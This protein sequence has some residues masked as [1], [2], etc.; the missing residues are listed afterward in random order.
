MKNTL[1]KIV[2]L[3]LLGTI[4]V[5]SCSMHTSKAD[6]KENI[7]GFYELETYTSKKESPEEDPYDRKAEEG[8]SAYFTIDMDGYGYYG[9]KDNNTPARV[10]AIF[11]TFAHDDEKPELYSSVEIKGT[12][13][14][15][16]AW[17]KKVGCLAEPPM[18]F[19]AEKK[20]STL[21]YTIP[22]YEYKIYTPSKIQKYQYVSY[23]KI[24]SETGYEVINQALGTSFSPDRPYEMKY[25]NSGY[26]PYRCQAKEGTG[27]GQKGI[28]EY[29]ILDMNSFANN[30]LNIIYSEVAN[31]GQHTVS[32][33][34]YVKEVGVSVAFVF[35]GKE[36]IS[37]ASSFGTVYNEENDIVSESFTYWYSSELTLEE[38]IA[39]ETV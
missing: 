23:K 29:A 31:P 1:F 15:V 7:V 37:N 30:K 26:Y 2:P 12:N 17:E 18:G 9:Y 10:D 4:S 20:K 19:K 27:I 13:K 22:W 6:K 14:T 11:A 34:V 36:F 35:N 32:V 25:M 38:I 16:Y 8:I 24:S 33:D 5:C 28:Y 39:Q 21:S 3:F